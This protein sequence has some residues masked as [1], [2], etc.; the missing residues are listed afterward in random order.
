[1][2][3]PNITTAD[4]CNTK[5]SY[6]STLTGTADIDGNVLLYEYPY[7]TNT[8]P[9]AVGIAKD[10][11]WVV[12]DENIKDGKIYSVIGINYSGQQMQLSTTSTTVCNKECIEVGS[13]SGTVED[14]RLGYVYVVDVATNEQVASGLV[15]DNKWQIKQKLNNAQNYKI[16]SVKIK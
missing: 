1:M 12:Q 6:Q 14:I 10:G 8:T 5:C 7:T 4:F 15:I 9:I 16:Y 2:R 3:I 13:F 11:V